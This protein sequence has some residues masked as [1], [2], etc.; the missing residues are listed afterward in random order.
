QRHDFEIVRGQGDDATALEPTPENISALATGRLRLRQR[1]GD[2]NA[3][4]LIKFMLP[5]VHNVYLHSTPARQLL[6]KSR[7]TFSHG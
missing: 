5:N 6:E 4:G 3:L 7:R 2:D 1:P